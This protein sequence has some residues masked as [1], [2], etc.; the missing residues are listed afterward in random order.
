MVKIQKTNTGQSI[1][2]IPRSIMRATGW[3]RGTELMPYVDEEGK[4]ILKEIK[5]KKRMRR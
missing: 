5:I 2:T 3:G 4:L 1:I